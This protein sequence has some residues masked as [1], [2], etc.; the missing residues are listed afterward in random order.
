MLILSE[1]I[2]IIALIAGGCWSRRV[3]IVFLPIIGASL[4][5]FAIGMG[6][7]IKLLVSGGGWLILDTILVSAV[8]I[9]NAAVLLAYIARKVRRVSKPADI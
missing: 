5:V 8:L 7:P 9:A 1:L 2:I 6:N 3:A 4:V